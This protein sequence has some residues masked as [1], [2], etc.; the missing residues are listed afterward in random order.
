MFASAAVEARDGSWILT[1][2]TRDDSVRRSAVGGSAMW[3][4][5][6]SESLVG[7]SLTSDGNVRFGIAEEGLW[8]SCAAKMFV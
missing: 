5:C 1:E 2:A 4:M 3:K 7:S 8:M 6:H